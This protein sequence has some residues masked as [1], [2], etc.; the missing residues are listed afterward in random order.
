MKESQGSHLSEFVGRD[1]R[2]PGKL[3]KTWGALH[4]FV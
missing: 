1:L 4:F 3:S 2:L